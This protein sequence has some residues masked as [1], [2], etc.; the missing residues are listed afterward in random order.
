[1]DDVDAYGGGE[2]PSK[3]GGRDGRKKKMSMEVQKEG[4]CVAD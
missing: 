4:G 2:L 1:L 3:N